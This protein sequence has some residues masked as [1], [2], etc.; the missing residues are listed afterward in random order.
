M[1]AVV[2][3]SVVKVLPLVVIVPDV[4]FRV[5]APFATVGDQLTDPFTMTVPTP[6][7]NVKLLRIA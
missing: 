2:T 3:K 4:Y 6:E 1:L 5:A 7:S